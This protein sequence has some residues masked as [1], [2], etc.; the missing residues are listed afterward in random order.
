MECDVDGP[1]HYLPCSKKTKPKNGVTIRLKDG[2]TQFF[3][4]GKIPEELQGSETVPGRMECDV[5]G[6]KFVAGKVMVINGI[7]TFIPGKVF[8]G[9]NGEEVFVPGKMINGKNGPHFVPGQVIET[10]DGNE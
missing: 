9:E 7:K 3:P 5:D 1:R 8:K 10:E 2:T 4:D 6:P